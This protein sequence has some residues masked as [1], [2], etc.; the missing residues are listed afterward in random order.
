VDQESGPYAYSCGKVDVVTLRIRLAGVVTLVMVGFGLGVGTPPV[1]AAI[2]DGGTFWDDD[3]NTHEGMIEAIAA[4]GVTK[5][6][7]VDQP[8]RFCSSL[9]V[10]RGQMASFLA[11]A[12]GLPPATDD[13]FLDDTGSTHEGNINRLFEAGITTG[14]PDGTYRPADP[15]TREQMA[16]FL[17]RAIPLVPVPG[18]QFTDVEGLHEQNINAIAAE[19]ITLGCNPVGTLYCPKELVRRDQMASFVGRALG[20]KAESIAPFVLGVEIVESGFAS[21]TFV[22]SPPDDSRLFVTELGGRVWIIEGGTKL[23]QPFLDLRSVVRSGGEQGLLG[24]AFHPEFATNGFVYLDYT[25]SGD[26]SRLVRYT[27][28]TNPDVA[29]PATRVELM[30]V[31]QPASNHNG[32]MLAFGPDGYLYWG[33]GDGGGSGDPYE[34]G[35]DPTTP[36]GSLLRLDVDGPPPYGAPGNPWGTEVWAIGLRNPWRFSFDDQT[37]LLY[38][39]DVGQGAWEEVD[40]VEPQPGLNFGWDVLEGT[41]CYEPATGCSS[42]GTVLPVVEYSHS[43]GRSVTGGYVYRSASLPYLDGAYIYGDLLGRVWSFRMVD[44][45]VMD[46]REWTDGLPDI[47][48]IWSFGR[49]AGGRVYIVSG[50]GTIYRVTG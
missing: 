50:G 11:R 42:A 21:P 38:I 43:V 27:V 3:G 15:V 45:K 34:N 41:H 9:P 20:L 26:D 19:G 47:G 7:D 33:L 39:G 48:S 29:D 1:T 4:L 28:G 37:G 24:L 8:G 12:F 18:D 46:H 49:D 10:T 32:G 22:T 25:D 40:V 17:A 16:S 2:P 30:K 35:Q 23:A 6:C 13:Y 36:L 14:Y 5:G 44:G 31:H